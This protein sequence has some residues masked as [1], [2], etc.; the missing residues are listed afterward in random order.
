MGVPTSPQCGEEGSGNEPGSGRCDWSGVVRGAWVGGATA[1]AGA[2]R[3]WAGGPSQ[4]EVLTGGGDLREAQVDVPLSVSH[5][6]V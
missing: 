1:V 3:G 2:L 4:A 6:C 5:T